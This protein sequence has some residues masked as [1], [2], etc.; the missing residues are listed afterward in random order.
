MVKGVDPT[1]YRFMVF[2]RWGELI[3]ESFYPTIGWDGYYKNLLSQTDVYV[4]KLSVV[5]ASSGKQYDYIGHVTL[6]K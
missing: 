1:Q 5:D 3:F 2:N 4:W 6:L